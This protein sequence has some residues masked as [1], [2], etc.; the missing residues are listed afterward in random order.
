M[1]KILLILLV[2]FFCYN[3]LDLPLAIFFHHN[4]FLLSIAQ[5]VTKLGGGLFI[6]L[7][8]YILLIYAIM[9]D[10]LFLAKKMIFIFSVF[11]LVALTNNIAKIIFAR[12]RPIEY[13]EHGFYGF[14][15]LSFGHH[16]ASFPSGHTMV[17]TAMLYILSK[18]W[19]KYFVGFMGAA[20]IISFSRVI[21]GAHYFSD[22]LIGYIFSIYLVDFFTE[23]LKV[24]FNSET[25]Y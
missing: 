22:V 18:I 20:A 15:F 6:S 3:F 21:V 10:N 2:F 4:T 23:H 12:A 13:F 19:P 11:L 16:F 1:K 17:I 8:L 7:S 5:D 14:K 9:K 25:A 24:I